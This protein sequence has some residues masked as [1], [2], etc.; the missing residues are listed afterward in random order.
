MIRALVALALRQ[1]KIDAGDF[2]DVAQ[3]C[4][5]KW[6]EASK[7]QPIRDQAHLAAFLAVTVDNAL[8]DI[9]REK[10]ASKRSVVF[11]DIEDH[12]SDLADRPVDLDLRPALAQA[13][14]RLT[15]RQRKIC[16]LIVDGYRFE[17]IRARL[18]ISRRQFDQDRDAIQRLF[19]RHGLKPL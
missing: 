15:R 14:P 16:Q 19:A 5:M 13:L 8:K 3:K 1:G 12:A 2:Q 7:D 4:S 18:R 6:W 10:L 11:E 9:L 17:E